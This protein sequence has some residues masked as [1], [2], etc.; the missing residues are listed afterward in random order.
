MSKLVYAYFKLY[1]STCSQPEQWKDKSITEIDLS[2]IT[3]RWEDASNL[4]EP[5]PSQCDCSFRPHDKAA[6]ANCSNARL[7]DI[8][9]SLPFGDFINHTELILAHNRIG[10]LNSLVNLPVYRNVTKFDLSHNSLKHINV[11]LFTPKLQVR[12]NLFRYLILSTLLS[13]SVTPDFYT[14]IYLYLLFHILKICTT[15]K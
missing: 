2:R 6:I 4:L 9:E 15:N 14:S 11:S 12:R 10:S 5:C 13:S 7:T 3:C 1:Q 8:P